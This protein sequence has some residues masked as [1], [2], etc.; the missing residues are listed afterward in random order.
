MEIT[1]KIRNLFF[2]GTLHLGSCFMHLACSYAQ[3]PHFSQ[4]IYS[5]LTINPANTGVFNG[6]IRASSIYRMQWFTITNPYKTASVAVDAPI[7]KKKMRGNDFFSAGINF[8]NDAQGTV[9]LTTSSYNGLIS[10][11]KFLGGKKLHYITYGY[12][13]GYNIKSVALGSIKYDSQY[14]P[15]SG[16]YNSAFGVNETSGGAAA[17][18]DMSTGLVWNFNSDRKFRSALGFSLHHFT[19]PDVSVIGRTDRLLPKYSFQWNVAYKLGTNSN[20]VLQPS[21]LV[22]KQGSSWLINGG[23]SVKYLLQERSRYTGFHGERSM[24]IGIFYRYLDAAY[25]NLRLD[26]EDFAFSVAYDINISGLTS[27]SKSVGGFEIMLQY[28]GVFGFTQNAKRS[29]DRFM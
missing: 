6:D 5:P 13:I 25:V 9:N 2:V 1:M 7:F 3:D 14:D 29:S 12:E 16:T 26:Y 27:V 17:F 15:N 11:T 28:R 18:L 4:S 8:I 21:L 22:S 19:A 23:T 20:A 24:A 10:Y